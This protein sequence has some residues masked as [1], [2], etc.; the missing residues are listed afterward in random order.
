MTKT[1]TLRIDE[2]SY[3]TFVERAKA[4][5]RSIANFIENAV[6][7]HIEEQDFVDDYEMAQIL[8]DEG[9]VKRLKKGSRE[10]KRKKGK[11][12]G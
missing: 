8:A 2:K 9:L 6:K 5:N 7:R 11:M 3:R 4:E 12:I 1:L 10:A